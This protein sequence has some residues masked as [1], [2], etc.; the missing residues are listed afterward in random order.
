MSGKAFPTGL[1]DGAAGGGA[2]SGL[3]GLLLP[4]LLLI[5]PGT[6]GRVVQP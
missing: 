4:D 1:G 2:L 3:F 6:R 5:A